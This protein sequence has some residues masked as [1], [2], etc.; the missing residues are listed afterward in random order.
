MDVLK[1][2]ERFYENFRGEKGVIGKSVFNNPIYYMA[3]KK[4]ETPKII[5]TYSIHARE[6]ITALLSLKQIKRFSMSA[7]FGTAYFVPLINPD[8]VQI[9]Q[10]ENPLYKANGRGV[11]LNV[12]FDA[13][14][15]TGEKNAFNSGAENYIGKSPFSEPET[16]A[17]RDFTLK[18]TPDL[19]ISYH[20]KGEEIYWEFFQ[21]ED[22]RLRDE[23]IAK[24]VADITG[25][26]IKSTPNSAGGY[27][28]WC[29]EKLK[30]PALTIEVGDDKLTHPI[31]KKYL[32]GIYKKNKFVAE[33]SAEFLWRENAK[34]IHETSD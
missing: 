7:K 24:L 6:Y 3:I 15:G 10:K 14:W 13:R 21:T 18:I 4:T 29:V 20:A 33:R 30:I 2:V 26:A 9:A 16:M 27:K 5:L 25:Y 19:T 11:D 31:G 17:I 34:K 8:G 23:K 32:R 22:N 28:D 12:N 1:K